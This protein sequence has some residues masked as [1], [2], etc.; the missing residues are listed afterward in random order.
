LQVSNADYNSLEPMIYFIGANVMSPPAQPDYYLSLQSYSYLQFY[1]RNSAI[2][3]TN[4]IQSSLSISPTNDYE[5][6]LCELH[7][8]SLRTFS[9]GLLAVKCSIASKRQLGETF[10]RIIRLMHIDLGKGEPVGRS[11]V[12]DQLQYFPLDHVQS[13][14]VY[15]IAIELS[16]IDGNIGCD[17]VTATLHIRKKAPRVGF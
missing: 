3:F 2:S 17:H 4:Q 1:P 14:N 9:P 8:A 16:M 7:F 13:T 5:V 6:A 12:F 10:E 15:E 11:F